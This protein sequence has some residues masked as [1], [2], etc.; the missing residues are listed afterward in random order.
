MIRLLSHHKAASL[1]DRRLLLADAQSLVIR[2]SVCK[3]GVFRLQWTDESSA[4]ETSCKPGGG[5][6][7][8]I[9][10][11][12]RAAALW[13]QDGEL[14]ENHGD[15][16]GLDVAELK[17]VL[18]IRCEHV[19]NLQQPLHHIF[20]SNFMF[21]TFDHMTLKG[22]VCSSLLFTQSFSSCLKSSLLQ[23]FVSCRGRNTI[24]TAPQTQMW[25][26]ELQ[27]IC[28][29]LCSEVFRLKIT[30]HARAAVS[31]WR[32]QFNKAEHVRLRMHLQ[33]YG[34]SFFLPPLLKVQ[35]LLQIHDSTVASGS[36]NHC[37]ISRQLQILL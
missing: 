20:H 8:L 36:T 18:L 6:K 10:G 31:I 33:I 25:R 15:Y 29:T 37:F 13:A 16:V 23:D 7:L 11:G 27:N 2:Y 19:L 12:R 35:Q 17:F 24:H 14:M 5:V 32:L 4:A 22:N 1:F 34:T 28:F 3:C 30:T 21:L 9:R 26:F